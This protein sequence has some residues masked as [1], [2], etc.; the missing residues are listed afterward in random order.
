MPDAG[1]PEQFLVLILHIYWI[2]DVTRVHDSPLISFKKPQQKTRQFSYFKEELT[3]GI[4]V[5]DG[6]VGHV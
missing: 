1:I 6:S 4:V 2:T 5:E 3:E